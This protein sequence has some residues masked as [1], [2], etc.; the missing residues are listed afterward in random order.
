LKE[1]LKCER[2]KLVFLILFLFAA[3]TLSAQIREIKTAFYHVVSNDAD[4]S[5]VLRELELRFDAYNQM[6]GFDTAALD[7]PLRV[8][9]FKNKEDYDAYVL[10][11]LGSIQS[12]AVYLHYNQQDRRELVIHRG[13]PE[14]ASA[15]PYQTFIQFLRAFVPNPPAWIRDGFAIFFSSLRFEPGTDTL[16]YTENL[17]WLEPVKSLG[18]KAPP[19]EPVLL[20]DDPDLPDQF[21]PLA[22][23]V[24]SFF[25]NSGIDIYTRTLTEIFMTL[26]PAA[27]AGANAEAVMRRINLRTDRETFHRDYRSYLAGRKTFAE[28]LRDGQTAYTQK[29]AA[30]AELS[31]REAG[32]LNPAHYAPYYYLGLLA[33]ERQE[34]SVAEAYYRLA[35]Q[36]GADP[37][38]V[39][40]A[41][42]LNAAMAGR[43]EEAARF[44]EDAAK[45][46]PA[47][48]RQRSDEI[49]QNLRK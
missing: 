4:A 12:G 40:F 25:L 32:N 44:L 13:S 2:L 6:F 47:R 38:L 18:D 36:Y 17:A 22:W 35:L 29:D 15:L 8:R 37:A 14:E 3:L 26:D 20:A 1:R 7:A 34:Y 11:R 21:Q 33:Y 10:A 16:G 24:V 49:I 23:S 19:L 43:R 42:G 45:A 28:L 46:S 9:A 48:Y 41:Q 31:F 39:N 27:S 5:V 30:A